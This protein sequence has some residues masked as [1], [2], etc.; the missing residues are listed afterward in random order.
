MQYEIF[1]DVLI[2]V[3]SVTAVLGA[4]IGGLVFFLLR[5]TLMKDISIEASKHLDKECRKLIARTDIQ[6]GV[7]YWM[8][9]SYDNSIDVTKRA[10]AQAGDVLE[11]TQVIFA[12]SNLGFYYAEKH[13]QQPLWQRKEEAINLTR[14]GF[15]KYSA[16]VPEFQKPDWIDNYIFVKAVFAQTGSEREEVIQL[17]NE[18]LLRGDL[19]AI[20]AYLEDSKKYVSELRLTS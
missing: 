6:L 2:I 3:V 1:R 15:E 17:I 9:K 8:Q 20:H 19:E 11:E 18:L 5:A 13:K 12:K 16:S 4:L 14:I 10:L 7:T